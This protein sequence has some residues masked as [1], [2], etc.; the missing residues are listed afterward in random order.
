MHRL[1]LACYAYQ[2]KPRLGSAA[3][4][5]PL[6]RCTVCSKQS[7]V[8]R[9]VLVSTGLIFVAVAAIAALTGT[10]RPSP[11]QSLA[12]GE[13]QWAPV[14]PAPQEY[15]VVR[16]PQQV[17]QQQLQLESIVGSPAESPPAAPPQ[18]PPQ[19]A[20]PQAPPVQQQPAVASPAPERNIPPPRP[21]KRDWS[22]IGNG[23]VSARAGGNGFG[24]AG[25]ASA[26]DGQD[27]SIEDYQKVKGER[28]FAMD[29]CDAKFHSWANIQ[30]CISLLFSKFSIDRLYSTPC[31][32]LKVL[33]SNSRTAPTSDYF[34]PP[35]L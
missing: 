29:F 19:A 8:V 1:Q 16:V 34:R 3:H 18:A 26:E 5:V 12:L 25:P 21:V 17:A 15:A 33:I 31:V 28:R 35:I 27:M 9:R 24:S 6:T 7:S 30:K 13:E 22:K 32:T 14:P 23:D 2:C 11:T 20:P 10:S 4:S